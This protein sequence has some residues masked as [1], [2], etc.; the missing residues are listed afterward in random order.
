MYAKEYKAWIAGEAI[1]PHIVK[2]FDTFK[3]FWAAKIMLVNQ[4]A[5][6]TGLHGYGMAAVNNDD[7]VVSYSKSIANFGAAY[8]A[9][10]EL[11]KAQGTTIASMQGQLQAM[12]QYCMALQQ[13]IAN[14]ILALHMQSVNGLEE[15]F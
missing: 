9:T 12:Q 2:T 7:S 4:T 11:V 3:T 8:A 6:P 13:C 14:L 15:P 1:R 5:I 10:Q